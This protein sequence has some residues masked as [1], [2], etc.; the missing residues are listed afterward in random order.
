M[1]TRTWHVDPAAL[2]DYV[3]GRLDALTGASVEQHLL[4]C[5]ACRIDIGPF[6]DEPPS[7]RCGTRSRRASSARS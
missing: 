1:S 3:E 4:G 7:T 2:A 6:V 5:G